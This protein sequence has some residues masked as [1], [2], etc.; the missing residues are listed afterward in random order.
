MVGSGVNINYERIL[1]EVGIALLYDVYYLI[2][3]TIIKLTMNHQE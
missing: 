2:C 3:L 1:A